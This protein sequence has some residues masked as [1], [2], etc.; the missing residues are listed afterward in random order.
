MNR[1]EEAIELVWKFVESAFAEEE[2]GKKFVRPSAIRCKDFVGHK[3]ST[4]ALHVV[5]VKYG[6]LYG[7]EYAN[8]L[9]RGVQRFLSLP[10]DFVCFTDDPAGL[11]TGIR[12][13]PI[14]NSYKGWWSKAH[15]FDQKSISSIC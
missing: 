2:P 6:K 13:L 10:H 5:C 1:K 9:F 7:P 3:S 12:V 14:N 8:K 15:I 11:D 4:D